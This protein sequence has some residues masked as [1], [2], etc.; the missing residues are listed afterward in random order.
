MRIL[1]ALESLKEED[2]VSFHMPGHK[3][4]RIIGD[5]Y[6]A[7]LN[8]DITEIPGADNLHAAE[9]CILETENLIAD[10]YGAEKSKIL[11]NGS[12]VGI[13]SMIMGT[14]WRDESLLVS[15]NTHQSVYNAVE[16]GGINPVY[17]MPTLDTQWGIV[18]GMDNDAILNRLDQDS[19][20]KAIVLTYPTYEGVAYDIQTIISD[21]HQRG[22]LV[23]VDEAHG[24]HLNTSEDL[25]TS[26]LTLGAD[27]VVQS[28]HK[29]LPAMTQTAVI[30]FSKKM[31]QHPRFDRVLWYLKTLQTSSPSYVLMYSIDVMMDV[32]LNQANTLTKEVQHW[33]DDAE[34]AINQLACFGVWRQPQQDFMKICLSIEPAYLNAVF[35]GHWLGETLRARFG[36]QV[37]YD[38]YHFC[39]LMTSMATRENDFKRLIEALTVLNEEIRSSHTKCEV[40]ESVSVDYQM[41]YK[42]M[43]DPNTKVILASHILNY[44]YE[45]IPME[46]AEGRI[47]YEY[48]IPY[49]PGIPIIVPGERIHKS[50]IALYKREA[51]HTV[52][53]HPKGNIRVV[54]E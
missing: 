35:N 18:T 25:P 29:T 10:Y 40:S 48:V 8:Y 39:L 16:M 46:E 23:L 54:K 37:E 13:L 11:V 49:P 9:A 42:N 34:K 41:V 47:S 1:K 17:V 20:I 12:T 3:N 51:M 52:L 21:C 19:S 31:C 38:M 28:F 50:V 43:C 24:A 30:H 7:I 15:R 45:L 33:I 36:I 4:G 27:I 14:V 5:A 53:S 6:K 2:L 32:V 22:I 26:S 44:E